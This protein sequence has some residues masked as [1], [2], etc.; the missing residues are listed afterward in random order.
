MRSTFSWSSRFCCS[1]SVLQCDPWPSTGQGFTSSPLKNKKNNERKWLTIVWE[2]V[3]QSAQLSLLQNCINLKKSWQTC[4]GNSTGLHWTHA[5]KTLRVS[6]QVRVTQLRTFHGSLWGS[7]RAYS[8]F[9]TFLGE[10]GDF[11]TQRY[12]VK[13]CEL[14]APSF[15]L[16]CPSPGPLANSHAHAWW[17]S[18]PLGDESPRDG[19]ERPTCNMLSGLSKTLPLTGRKK[20]LARM[21]SF[22]TLWILAKS[23]SSALSPKVKLN[24]HAAIWA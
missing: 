11:E 8:R 16:P 21:K 7:N 17:R 5:S 4:M 22:C 12:P 20:L 23:N 19:N 1:L 24:K 3:P 6:R 13:H 18:L 14:L 2:S 10:K 9:H 15:L